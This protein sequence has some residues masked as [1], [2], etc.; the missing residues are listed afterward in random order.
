MV[1]DPISVPPDMPTIE[2]VQLMRERQISALPVVRDDQL[3]GI[4]TERDFMDLAGQLLEGEFGNGASRT[5]T[6]PDAASP[7]E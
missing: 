5:A 4:I 1:S 3:V 6:I 2:A 7:E